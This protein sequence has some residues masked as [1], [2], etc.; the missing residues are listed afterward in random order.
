MSE[1]TT[2]SIRLKELRSNLKMTQV[3]FANYVGTNQVTL[4]AYETGSTNPSLEI[5]KEIATKCNVS[6]DWLCGL[7]NKK[8]LDDECL[9]YYDALNLLVKLCSTKYEETQANLLTP[10]ITNDNS[11]KY[12]YINFETT[13]DEVI[14]PFFK[15]WQ[16]MY[17]L[18]EDEVI[19]SDIY[20]QWLEGELSKYKNHPINGV[21]F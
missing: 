10:N 11:I 1:Q 17:T 18:L 13:C 16:K 14:I 15:N 4:S 9:T 3:Q 6:I 5:V 19:N 7:S 2:F 12:E 21:P 20:N 8:N